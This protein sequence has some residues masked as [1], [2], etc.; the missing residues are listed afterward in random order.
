MRRLRLAF[1][2]F[3]YG[4]LITGVY[5]DAEPNNTLY[6]FN[7]ESS[8]NNFKELKTTFDRYL[9]KQGA[10]SFQ[11]FN[12]EEA[13]QE[14]VRTTSRV[15]MLVSEW[16]YRAL[17]RDMALKPL[18]IAEKEQES[19]TQRIAVTRVSNSGL[20]GYI[21]ASAYHPGDA[22]RIA[23]SLLEHANE[24]A[25]HYLRVPKDLDAL[26]SVGFGMADFALTTREAYEDLVKLNPALAKELKVIQT[27]K[28]VLRLIVATSSDS[29][30][31]SIAELL[32]SMDEH[33]EGLKCLKML[34]IDALNKPSKEA[35]IHLKDNR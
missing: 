15:I 7:Q 26:M 30:A 33:P 5:A 4:Y 32:E 11:P 13:F 35:L 19:T 10:Y 34:G 20:E 21:V 28:T 24:D 25:L 8:I 2:L 1:Q 31:L 27:G 17:S 16:E 18:L 22:E 3:L 9:L 6:Y 14:H 12:D 29:D 23:S